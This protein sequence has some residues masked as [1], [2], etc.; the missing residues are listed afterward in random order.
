MYK[1][2]NLPASH[3]P[4]RGGRRQQ[5]LDLLESHDFNLQDV[6]LRNSA[7]IAL[8]QSDVVPIRPHSP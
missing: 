6:D 2:M 4:D 7:L 3:R 5:M 8:Q 1:E